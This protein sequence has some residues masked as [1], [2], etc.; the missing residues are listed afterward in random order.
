MIKK[1]FEF[2]YTYL[3]LVHEKQIVRT[4][5]AWVA[6][7]DFNKGITCMGSFISNPKIERELICVN[8]EMFDIG[9]YK[10]SGT[11]EIFFNDHVKK[12]QSGNYIAHRCQAFTR[13]LSPCAFK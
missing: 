5:K 6:E 12:I 10:C 2:N 9:G 4:V 7:I 3:E 13:G 11:W 8:K 1:G